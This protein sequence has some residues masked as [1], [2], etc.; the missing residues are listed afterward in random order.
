[1][2]I[3]EDRVTIWATG[4]N[5]NRAPISG[6][7]FLRRP[8]NVAVLVF[9]YLFLAMFRICLTSIIK[10]NAATVGDFSLHCRAMD[11]LYRI[12]ALFSF[13]DR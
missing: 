12:R 7:T 5:D 9:F 13:K 6:T 10:I 2:G 8:K 11:L 3:D 1:M 4:I